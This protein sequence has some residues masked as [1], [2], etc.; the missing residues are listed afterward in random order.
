MHCH[1]LNPLAEWQATTFL[2]ISEFS[3]QNRQERKDEPGPSIVPDGLG[4]FVPDSLRRVL[5]KSLG[6]LGV[7]WVFSVRFA[8]I[9]AINRFRKAYRQEFGV[10]EES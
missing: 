9:G 1:S 3:R 6:G 4:Q 2:L 8:M 10:P 7:L 5:E